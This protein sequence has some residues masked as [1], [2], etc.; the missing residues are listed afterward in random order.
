MSLSSLLE[1]VMLICF[2]A[3]WPFAVYKTYT[4]KSSA[5]KSL[6]FL[7]LVLIGYI[8]GAL[9]KVF[10]ECNAVLALYIVNGLM[11]TADLTLAYRYRM[12]PAAAVSTEM[13]AGSGGIGE[14]T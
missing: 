6:V 3:S 7:W 2:G 1:T 4:S 5:G 10:G 14:K 13:P 11:V 8:A 12:R 9:A